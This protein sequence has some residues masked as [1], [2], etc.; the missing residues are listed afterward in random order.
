MRPMKMNMMRG[1][2]L[3]ILMK[4]MSITTGPVLELGSGLYSSPYLHWECARSNRRLVT[5]EGNEDYSHWILKAANDWHEVHYVTDW[6][7]IDL[8]ENWSIAFVD[9]APADRRGTDVARLLHADYVVCHD[10][11]NRE[12]TKYNYHKVYKSFKYRW[13]Y[14]DYIPCTSV[15]SKYHDVRNFR[16]AP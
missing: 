8:T 5:Y 7:K 1:S 4:L 16:I 12:F 15:W 6:D 3:P 14:T 2:H 10:T 11:E 9:H 13:K